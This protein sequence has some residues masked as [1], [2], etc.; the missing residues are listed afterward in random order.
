MD[1]LD[2]SWGNP[3]NT[4]FTLFTVPSRNIQ[5]RCTVGLLI[6][7]VGFIIQ[8]C[9][10]SYQGMHLVS[11]MA[12]IFR[13]T[14]TNVLFQDLKVRINPFIVDPW[15][16]K[17][18]YTNSGKNI[19]KLL[20]KNGNEIEDKF[21]HLRKQGWGRFYQNFICLLR[22]ILLILLRFC[23]ILYLMR[24]I[25]GFSL[26]EYCGDPTLSFIQGF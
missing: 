1:L 8:V 7:S 18:E 22:E 23:F 10:F 12:P 14:F 13:N 20:D 6:L 5:V 3:L 17:I 2:E 26:S 9:K 4:M 11:L 21:T 25:V 19:S 16:N 24:H 15:P